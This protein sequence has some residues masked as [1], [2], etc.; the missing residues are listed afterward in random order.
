MRRS[1]YWS[2]FRQEAID[3]GLARELAQYG[4]IELLAPVRIS[5]RGKDRIKG[6]WRERTAI[7]EYLPG[8]VL[9][10]EWR[11]ATAWETEEWSQLPQ[12]ELDRLIV[13]KDGGRYSIQIVEKIKNL[14][15]MIR[16][17]ARHVVGS[18]IARIR[19]QFTLPGDATMLAT[20]SERL[21]TITQQVLQPISPGALQDVWQET[22]Q[23]AL[24]LE[25]S[26]TQ[27]KQRA[28]E[29][30]E[31]A[32]QGR[33]WEIAVHTSQATTHLL[34]ERARAYEIA[35]QELVLA[36]QLLRLASAT[37]RRFRNSYLRLGKLGEQLQGILQTTPQDAQRILTV[38]REGLGIYQHLTERV[39][40]FNPYY[41]RLQEPQ[42]QRLSR[43][44]EHATA[45]R[46]QTV[47]ND[48]SEAA[49][50]LE[51]IAIRGRPSQSEIQQR[52]NM[53]L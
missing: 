48:I 51:A 5:I 3:E 40:H 41:E 38:A 39:P 30:I 1:A 20:Y 35:L 43:A 53:L 50:K 37:D 22:G 18:K 27:F 6:V 4:V 8:Q 31:L 7:A 12:G 29:E 52:R 14:P 46:P 26:K 11:E 2:E 24:L 25:N 49:A 33:F 47:Y 21:G 44:V 42:F 34:S 17:R 16:Q 19:K 36:E 23:L 15:A 45:G 28:R 32:Q 13:F 10:R 9:H